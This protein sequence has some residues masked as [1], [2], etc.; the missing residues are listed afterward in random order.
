MKRSAT[1]HFLNLGHAFD[2]LLMLIFPTV[3]LVMAPA[4]GMAY[5]EMLQ[6]SL[7]GFIAFGA[8]SLPAGWLAD[9]WSRWGM[10]V[11]FFVGIGLATMLVGLAQSPWQVAVGLTLVGLFAA[12]YHPVGIAMLVAGRDKVG[13]TLGVN[14]V[15]GNLGVA[16]AALSA[17]ALGDFLG[18]R[19]AFVI[20][21]A[22]AVAA[23]IA[24]AWLVPKPDRDLKRRSAP[25]AKLT[26]EVFLRVFAVLVVATVCGG[27]IFNATTIA[28]PK[29]FDER[30]S[31]LTNSAFGVGL[32]VSLVYVLA[33]M[34]QLIVGRLI[35]QHA[36]RPVFVGISALQAP[37]LLLAAGLSDWAMLLAA[38][39]MMF[40]VFGQIPINDAIIAKYTVEEWRARVYALRYVVSFVASA[41]AVPLVAFMHG[42]FGGFN[43]LYLVLAGLAALTFLGAMSFPAAAMARPT[44]AKA[45]A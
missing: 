38:I 45:A 42:A 15:W 28:M 9:R 22:A 6:L 11:V 19:W 29:V 36:L 24:F 32:L 40:A 39:G 13:T 26:R 30:L 7:G 5:G 41:C 34:A 25:P 33:A 37:F 3:I 10:M 1:E 35:D 14:G 43:Q 8:G 27:V 4:F 21:G 20:P 18:W 17:G 23:G 12:I 44:A 31:A 2:H 16:A